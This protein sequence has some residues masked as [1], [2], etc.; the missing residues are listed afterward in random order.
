MPSPYVVK[1]V[2]L[3]ETT[4]GKTSLL[5]CFVQEKPPPFKMPVTIGIDFKPKTVERLV[6]GKTE[7]VQA[8][9]W[10]TAGQE[11]FRALPPTMYKPDPVRKMD[12]VAFIVCY[13]ITT[14]W[15]F[16]KG[17]EVQSAVEY[18]LDQ[19]KQHAAS[20]SVVCLV[21]NKLDLAENNPEDRAVT[22]EEGA[23]MAKKH[24]VNYFFETSAITGK[25]VEDMFLK[26]LDEVLDR[27]VKAE[28]P[29]EDPMPVIQ[30]F[31][32]QL[33]GPPSMEAPAAGGC[34]LLSWINGCPRRNR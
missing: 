6:N 30:P 27:I 17:T 2:I 14:R 4:V 18:W 7:Q 3:G 29:E 12:P 15:T 20:N 9:V 23:E 24:G 19:V 26:V 33:G 25:N 13:D 8:M 31:S 5:K 10:D 28:D 1:V 21:G 22:T 32:F 11:R 16:D 34:W